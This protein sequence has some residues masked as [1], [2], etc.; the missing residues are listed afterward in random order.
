MA[1]TDNNI[2]APNNI[3]GTFSEQFESFVKVGSL[4]HY[5]RL[6]CHKL[7]LVCLALFGACMFWSVGATLWTRNYYI[8]CLG[9]PYLRVILKFMNKYLNFWSTVWRLPTTTSM[10]QTRQGKPTTTCGILVASSELV[11]QL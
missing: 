10:H 7:L 1:P 6:K 2:H 5:L 11:N 9:C 8:C 3:S 4:I